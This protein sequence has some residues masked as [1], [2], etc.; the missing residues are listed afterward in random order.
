MASKFEVT[1]AL[2]NSIGCLESSLAILRKFVGLDAETNDVPEGFDPELLT[3]LNLVKTGLSFAR[4]SLDG[5]NAG[6]EVPEVDV[7][8]LTDEQLDRGRYE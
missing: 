5:I 8:Y 4:P 7:M 3:S 2:E 1:A 6:L